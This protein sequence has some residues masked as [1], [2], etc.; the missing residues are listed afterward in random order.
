[1]MDM[2]VAINWNERMVDKGK[3]QA[4]VTVGTHSLGS[5]R[6]LDGWG[7]GQELLRSN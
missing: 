1:M 2:G 7:W 6:G 5:G 4:D 3:R